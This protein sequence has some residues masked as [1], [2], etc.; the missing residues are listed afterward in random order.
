MPRSVKLVQSAPSG[1]TIEEMVMI[2]SRERELSRKNEGQSDSESSKAVVLAPGYSQVCAMLRPLAGNSDRFVEDAL[3]AACLL[4]ATARKPGNV[5]P[6]ASFPDLT[7]EHFREAAN[8]SAPIVARAGALGVGLAVKQAV[9]ATRTVAPSNT[10]LGILLLLAPLAAVPR[11]KTLSQGIG[12]VL[13]RLTV[14][15]SCNVYAAI[16]AALPG[17]MGRV[18]N[19]DVADEPTG[20]LREVMSLAAERDRIARQYACNFDDVLDFAVSRLARRTDFG[21]QWEAAIIRLHLELLARFPDTLIAR[22]C[23]AKVATE[24]SQ[25]AQDV[26]EAGWPGPAEAERALTDFDA[27]LRADG[28]RRNPGT[29]A[30]L[31]AA[32]LFAAIREGLVAIP[33]LFREGRSKRHLVA[34]R[35]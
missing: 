14:E 6:H 2:G 15:D 19:Q 32:T 31:V 29:T 34:T 35:G 20:T 17:G 23:G 3:W 7:Y 18:E 27:W 16:S 5:H 21:D 12:A 13:D 24:A 26:L 4:E 8:V 10:N 33:E 9:D 25:R 30:D 22:K 28:N 11:S 1:R